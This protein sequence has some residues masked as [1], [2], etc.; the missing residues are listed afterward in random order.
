MVILDQGGID[1]ANLNSLYLNFNSKIKLSSSKKDNL[2]TGRDAL[3]D[4][5]KDWFDDKGK[6]KPKFYQQGSFAM[7]VVV[8]PLDDEEYDLDDGVYLQGYG[9]KDK[10]EWPSAVTV[11]KWVKDATN[12]RTSKESTDKN[13]CVRINYAD[14]YHIDLPIYIMKDDVPFLAHKA[15]GWTESDP[16]E[17]TDWFS[18]KA[19]DTDGQLR[20]VVRY[21]KAWRDYKDISLKSIEIT[22]L[23]AENYDQYEN[24]DDKALLYTVE[25]II[26]S[27]NDEFICMKPSSPYNNLFE[28]ISDSKKD[29]ILSKFNTLHG[30][31]E[32]AINE[33]D[34]EKASDLMKDMF[35]DRFPKGSNKASTSFQSTTTPGVLKNDAR[36]G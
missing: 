35:G 16:K 23:A 19:K 9:D 14:D 13:T 28:G 30:K 2:I 5:I 34:E 31:I 6:K 15:E 12:E 10:E 8:N 20:R 4:D 17:F 1:M 7:R 26:N 22:I 36:S 21:L 29:T 33:S 25:N 24:R 32:K 11:H 18:D 27:L 3:R